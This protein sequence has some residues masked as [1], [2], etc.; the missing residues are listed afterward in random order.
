MAKRVLIVYISAGAGHMRAS[1]AL[2]KA[3]ALSGGGEEVRCVDLLDYSNWL[4]RTLQ[5]D[6]YVKFAGKAPGLFALI[7]DHTDRPW[8]RLGTEFFDEMCSGALLKM[9]DDFKPNVIISTHGLVGGLISRWLGKKRISAVHGIVVT[10]FDAHAAWLCRNYDRYF[11]GIEETRQYLQ[12]VG[13]DGDKIT[14]SGI[15]IDPIFAESKERGTLLQKYGFDA[16]PLILVSGGGFGMGPMAEIVES[17]SELRTPSQIVVLCGR[18]AKLQ[19]RVSTI[20]QRLN[21]HLSIQAVGFTDKVDEYMTMATLIV[22]KSGGLFSSE[23]LAKGRVCV[24]VRP[25]SG[26]ETRNSDHLLENGAAVRCNNLPVLPR[27]VD[28]L[29]ADPQRL[30]QMEANATRMSH[31]RAAFTVVEQLQSH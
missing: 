5:R 12:R 9:I 24:I 26:Q 29:L 20:G 25:I 15:P 6:V 16:R 1:Q 14:V 31:S 11:V 7:Y 18:N 22:G 28:A 10:D 21:S 27:K 4:Y 19:A 8:K 2:E 17:L 13:I 30:A 3:Y 23:A